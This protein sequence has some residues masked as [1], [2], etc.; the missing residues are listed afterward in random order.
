MILSIAQLRKIVRA[1]GGLYLDASEFTLDQLT[2]LANAA[3]AGAKG[4]IA[5]RNVAGMSAAQLATL[6]ALAP[7]LVSFEISG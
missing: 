3:Q 4:S 2:E 1:G 6:A 5:L 7:G